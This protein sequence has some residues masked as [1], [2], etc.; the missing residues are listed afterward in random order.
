M[1]GV[2][3][4]EAV[5]TLDSETGRHR[6][7]VFRT[8]SGAYRVDVERLIEALDAGGD[9]RGEFWSRIRGITSYADSLERAKQMATENLWCGQAV[10]P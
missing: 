9:R 4:S 3:I 7:R 2:R 10:E 1:D 6:A 8:A 5:F